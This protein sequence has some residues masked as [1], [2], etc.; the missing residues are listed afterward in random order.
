MDITRAHQAFNSF[1]MGERGKEPHKSYLGW[2]FEDQSY[3]GG[4]IMIAKVNKAT[5]KQTP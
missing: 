1:S 2:L 3:I 4:T 5:L